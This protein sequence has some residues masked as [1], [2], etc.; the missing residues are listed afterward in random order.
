MQFILYRGF[1][2]VRKSKVPEY[3]QESGIMWIK[4]E[5]IEIEKTTLKAVLEFKAYG[6]LG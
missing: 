2:T 4:C 5:H 6:T 3:T 1:Q